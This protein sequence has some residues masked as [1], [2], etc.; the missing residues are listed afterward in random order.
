M[1]GRKQREI[2]KITARLS[3]GGFDPKA[4]AAFR[5]AWERGR[6]RNLTFE[7]KLSFEKERAHFTTLTEQLRDLPWEANTRLIGRVRKH[8]DGTSIIIWQDGRKPR[9]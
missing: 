6:V 4:V 5:E 2:E 9:A 8:Q 3:R 1:M 7:V